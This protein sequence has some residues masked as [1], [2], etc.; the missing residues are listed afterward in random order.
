[1]YAAILMYCWYP[2]GHPDVISENFD[3]TMKSYFGF[4]KVI[5]E[6]PRQMD[7]PLLPA[8][9]GKKGSKKLRNVLCRTCAEEMNLGFCKHE[10]HERWLIGTYNTEELQLALDN[11]YEANYR[12]VYVLEVYH[13]S[14]RQ[15][16]LCPGYICAWLKIKLTSSGKPKRRDGETQEEATERF[17][18]ECFEE[19]GI[20]ITPDEFED[21]PTLRT[22]AKRMLNSF[23]GLSAHTHCY[24]IA[25]N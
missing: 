11:P 23:W 4:A 3:M 9:W 2:M 22:L 14:K 15:K 8:R 13:Y 12:M 19:L 16:G 7:L 17:C 25:H 10:P 20:V 24:F 18:R 1:M 6:P 5:I 21:N